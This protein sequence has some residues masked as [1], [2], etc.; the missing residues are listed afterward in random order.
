MYRVVVVLAVA[1]CGFDVTTDD[2]VGTW[3]NSDDGVDRALLFEAPDHTYEVEVDAALVQSGTYEVADDTLVN[4]DGVE[5]EMDNVLVWTVGYDVSGSVTPGTRFGDPIY[6][7][8]T[9]EMVLRSASG[10]DGRRTW[11]REE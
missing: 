11:V 6:D 1:G 9:D 3:T 2:L 4:V 7:Y 10:E 8:G 5:E